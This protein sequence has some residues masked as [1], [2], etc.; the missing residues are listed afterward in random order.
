MKRLVSVTFAL[1]LPLLVGSVHSADVP[2]LAK[3]NTEGDLWWHQMVSMSFDGHGNFVSPHLDK[4]HTTA[5]SLGAV[6]YHGPWQADLARDMSWMR[7]H[8]QAFANHP[9]TKRVVYIEGS[10]AQK[11]LARVSPDGAVLFTLSQLADLGDPKRRRYIESL[12]KPGGR[13]VWFSDWEFMQSPL[14]KTPLGKPLP[15]AKEI[16]PPAFTN[17]LDGGAITNE[18]DFWRTRSAVMRRALWRR[19]V[20]MMAETFSPSQV[21]RRSLGRGDRSACRLDLVFPEQ[22][23]PSRK[24]RDHQSRSEK[25]EQTGKFCIETENAPRGHYPEK[26]IAGSHRVNPRGKAVLIP[27]KIHLADRGSVLGVFQD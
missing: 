19:S 4:L 12:I 10:S 17:P 23:N 7:G 13:T 25:S 3:A 22:P 6:G 5:A 9:T 21:C 2:L 18:A 20:T 15:T 1:C 8:E 27:E 26:E 16:G 14:L 24:R 11:V